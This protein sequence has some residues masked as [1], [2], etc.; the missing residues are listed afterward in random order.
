MKK[1]ILYIKLA[2]YLFEM[3]CL[4]Y[5]AFRPLSRFMKLESIT[6]VYLFD[7]MWYDA[8]QVN[9]IKRELELI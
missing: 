7:R 6:L 4:D 3:N 9:I 2:L 5:L 1:L 8:Q